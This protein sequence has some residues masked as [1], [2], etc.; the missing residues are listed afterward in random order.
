MEF[1][2]NG[3]EIKANRDEHVV[4][5]QVIQGHSSTFVDPTLAGLFINEQDIRELALECYRSEID[6]EISDSDAADLVFEETGRCDNN[7]FRDS[8]DFAHFDWDISVPH[9]DRVHTIY[10]TEIDGQRALF[11]A[12]SDASTGETRICRF[13]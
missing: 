4:G 7:T 3:E 2:N 10:Y 12:D 8:L 1:N 5:F 6:W 13:H 9:N 11:S